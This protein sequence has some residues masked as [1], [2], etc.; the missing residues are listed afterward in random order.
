MQVSTDELL[1]IISRLQER[2]SQAER[3]KEE[4][5]KVWEQKREELEGRVTEVREFALFFAGPSPSLS[6][7][8]LLLPH[9]VFYCAYTVDPFLRTPLK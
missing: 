6:F 7:L 3:E 8:V 2:L 4:E 9:C 1:S 5:D